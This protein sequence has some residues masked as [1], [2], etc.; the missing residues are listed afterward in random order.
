MSDTDTTTAAA[1]SAGTASGPDAR[2]PNV[3][4]HQAQRAV[5]LSRIKMIALI[6]IYAAPLLAAWLWL[7][8]VRN[9]EGAG[10]R[11]NGELITPAVPVSDF[12]LQDAAGE[13]WGL[14]DLKE[15][16]SMVYFSR[17]ACGAECEKSLYNMRQV[18]L[19]TGRRM[20]RV[21]RVFVT[22]DLQNMADKLKQAGE[23]LA[24]VGGTSEQLSLLDT[25][26]KAAQDGMTPCTGCIYL[27]DP[28]G[29]LMMR[30]SPDLDP[31]KMYKDLKHLLKV[32][33]IG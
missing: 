26:F 18:R 9:N 8:Y 21:Q 6:S 13:Q 15:K 33:R 10:V 2:A 11:V 5:T 28:F 20:D 29:N 32:S 16:W 12:A 7:G 25:Q 3:P 31:K 30:F 23:G 4:D 17:D 14:N 24:V 27:V 22:G 19:S 1:K